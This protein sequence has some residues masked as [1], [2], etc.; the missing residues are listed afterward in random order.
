[1]KRNLAALAAISVFGLLITLPF[2]NPEARAQSDK[3]ANS[4]DEFS[5]DALRIA[6]FI[7]SLQKPD[8][9]IVDERGGNKVNEDSNMEYALI[10]LG[11][12]YARSHQVKYLKGLEKGIQ[13]LADREEMSDPRWKGSWFFVYSAQTGEHLPSSPG[14]GMMDA[15]GVDA[16]SAVF[17][18]LL[19]LDSRLTHSSVFAGKFAT[20]GRAALNFVLRENLAEDGLSQ[21]SW[22]QSAKDR[23]WTL[24]EEQYSADQGDVYL[25]M[26]AGELLYR[27]ATYARVA[28]TLKARTP[29]LI[30]VPGEGRY[31]LGRDSNGSVTAS[32]DGIS[33]AFSQ[34][35]LSW[36]WGNT[37]ANHS[38]SQW[39]R[40]HVQSDGSLVTVKGKP[41]YTLNIAMLGMAD[42]ALRAPAPAE[43]FRWLMTHT[44][45]TGTGG[46][47]HS[48]ELSDNAESNNEAGFC[49]LALT[50]FLPFE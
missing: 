18:Y 13:W 14:P 24:F 30:F 20:N 10:G 5:S 6:D 32:D 1:M 19:Y 31:G 25:G 37:A 7:L 4:A 11:A 44:Y 50:G 2:S 46:V 9:A 23:Q 36:M 39:L 48:T 27:D 47:H 43:S 21:S 15:R 12:A 8:G 17:T 40:A 28:D 3:S 16:T 35:Y 42:A 34:G 33:A 41:S 38:A 49:I 45:D 22:L 26:H 29:E